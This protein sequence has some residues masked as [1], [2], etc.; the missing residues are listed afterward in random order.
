MTTAIIDPCTEYARQFEGWYDRI[1]PHDDSA[2]PLVELLTALHPDPSA[3]TLEIGVGTGRIALPLSERVGA[4]TGV[5]ISESMLERLQERNLGG[6]VTAIQG[7]MR[8]YQDDRTY[9]LVYIVCSGLSLLLH[10][11]EQKEAVRRAADRVAPGGRLVLE[12][13][14]GPGC[15]A[16]HEGRRQASMMTR[17]PEPNTALLTHMTVMPGQVWKC[18]HIWFESDGTHRIASEVI[19]LLERSELDEYAGAA[20]LTPVQHFGDAFGNPLTD[21]A[22]MMIGVYQKES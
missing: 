20:G 11:E 5:D 1:F 7:D 19:R 9:G 21:D 17:Y 6:A 3:G 12:V 4:I 13:H 16:F 22:A 15:L 8:T 10:P 14:H 2:T 18:D